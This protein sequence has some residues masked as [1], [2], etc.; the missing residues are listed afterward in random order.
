MTEDLVNRQA[1][2]GALLGAKLGP[3]LVKHPLYLLE[4]TEICIC[5][6]VA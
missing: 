6:Y 2:L 3:S 5:V 4:N 1:S